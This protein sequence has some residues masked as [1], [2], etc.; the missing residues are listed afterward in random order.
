V[1]A[2]GEYW[3]P[4]RD[5]VLRHT[6]IAARDV[7]LDV[8]AGDGLI[9][10]G[11]LV[12]VGEQGRV[13]FS[14]IS[15][16]CLAYCQALHSRGACVNGIGFCRPA[17]DLSALDEASIDK[18]TTRFLLIYVAAKQR[19]FQEFY[20]I[21]RRHG[22]LSIFEPINRYFGM[23]GP[24]HYGV[25]PIQELWNKI[26]AVDERIQPSTIS[27]VS[28]AS[29]LLP[30]VAVVAVD[31]HRRR[32]LAGRYREL[33]GVGLGRRLGAIGARPPVL[34]LPRQRDQRR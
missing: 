17:D 29:K 11:A 3:K 18:V 6:K 25:A 23:A 19:A 7:V 14:D 8:G 20:P 16:D 27:P 28:D 33:V 5:Q 2:C 26:R 13:I 4:V 21:L 1:W 24:P 22:R 9:A 30:R 10:F 12:Q 15:Q 31:L 34:R 32:T